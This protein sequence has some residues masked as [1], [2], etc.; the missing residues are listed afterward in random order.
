MSFFKFLFKPSR[1]K[2]SV[3]SGSIRMDHSD[4][5]VTVHP[6]FEIYREAKDILV[7]QEPFGARIEELEADEEGAVLS[8]VVLHLASLPL[9]DLLAIRAWDSSPD[10]VPYIKPHF[11]ELFKDKLTASQISLLPELVGEL[12]SEDSSGGLILTRSHKHYDEY[13]KI[14]QSTYFSDSLEMHTSGNTW[15]MSRLAW[16][17]LFQGMGVLLVA[18]SKA[19]WQRDVDVH[20]MSVWQLILWLDKDGW[21][22]VSFD[23]DRHA[24]KKAKS[25]PHQI[26][27]DVKEWYTKGPLTSWLYL[28][29]LVNLT[30]DHRKRNTN[31]CAKTF[32][33]HLAKPDVYR[34]LL[35]IAP[36]QSHGGKS[37]VVVFSN[38]NDDFA[39]PVVIEKAKAAPAKRKRVVPMC[40]AEDDAM[41]SSGESESHDD[42]S[43]S[44]Y[45]QG[46][47]D[48]DE[49]D[50]ASDIY[51]HGHGDGGGDAGYNDEDG[52]PDGDDARIKS[53][54]RERGARLP[55][56]VAS[57]VWGPFRITTTGKGEKLQITC[58]HPRHKVHRCNKTTSI[59]NH[60]GYRNTCTLLMTWA[61]WGKDSPSK[62]EHKKLWNE[63]LTAEEQGSLPERTELEA[64]GNIFTWSQHFIDDGVAAV[65]KA[66]AKAKP[67]VV[68]KAT[69]VTDSLVVPAAASDAGGLADVGEVEASSEGDSS[70][71]D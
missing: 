19:L 17:I 31:S 71:W 66:K 35:G 10:L 6:I 29:A 48:D 12:V 40:D 15:K 21:E 4:I 38:A 67:K 25:N 9:H 26:G 5:G 60:G 59:K 57:W 53:A 56:E 52:D 63:I 41:A 49:S 50:I 32:V 64:A 55:S 22:Q 24:S 39:E 45:D 16:D 28:Q 42:E 65:A 54:K 69:P 62:S 51:M 14:L 1:K 7:S 47:S 44:D 36:K 58:S 27:G 61:M 23:S 43:E 68:A 30:I 37:A 20:E 13:N 2:R 18:S 46:E 8:P 34:R 70:S 33:P 3:A 11:R